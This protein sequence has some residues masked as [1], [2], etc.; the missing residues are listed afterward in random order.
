MSEGKKERSRDTK[1]EKRYLKIVTITTLTFR[2]DNSFYKGIFHLNSKGN[3]HDKKEGGANLNRI[4]SPPYPASLIGQIRI[5]GQ[6][7]SKC[8]SL[9]FPTPD[10][11]LNLRNPTTSDTHKRF[12]V[13]VAETASPFS[14]ITDKCEVP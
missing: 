14:A 7:T 4:E 12:I 1:T 6:A 8:I 13:V 10:P 5:R 2:E 9:S 11:Q 3:S